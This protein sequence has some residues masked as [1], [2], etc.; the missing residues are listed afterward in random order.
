MQIS[1]LDDGLALTPHGEAA[2]KGSSGQSYKA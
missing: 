1:R 2:F